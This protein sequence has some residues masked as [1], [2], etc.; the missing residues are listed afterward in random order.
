[1]DSICFNSI[2]NTRIIVEKKTDLILHLLAHFDI[3]SVASNYDSGY[4]RRING[5]KGES[6][7]F[8][9]DEF[10]EIDR[11]NLVYL[12][13]MPAFFS[14]IDSL[15][16]GLSY[17][18]SGGKVPIGGFTEIEM[19]CLQFLQDIFG[20]EQ[21]SCLVKF[22][23]M[24]RSEYDN[25]FSSYW[26]ENKES[27]TAELQL[28]K[29][30]W[31]TEENEE[32]L[33]FLRENE[34]PSI[35]VYLSEAMRKN[36]RGTRTDDSSVCTIARIPSSSSQVFESYYTA[37]HELLHQVIDGITQ[38]IL[39]VNSQERSLNP[40]DEGYSIHEQIENSVIY[41]QHLLMKETRRIRAKEYYSF[42]S[43]IVDTE[44]QNEAEFLTHFKICEEMKHKLDRMLAK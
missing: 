15:F 2:R 28:F 6:S 17:L 22:T 27:Y 12:S 33:S 25:F 8:L 34:I 1:M 3:N 40:D 37:V 32:I 36:G 9:H 20:T 10:K 31:E 11:E 44:I 29:K 18:S 21:L 19:R 35:T 42:L 24:A 23:E 30:I 7:S 14:N 13:F 26:D 41:A 5:L 4:A 43:E 38:R 39:K 16:K